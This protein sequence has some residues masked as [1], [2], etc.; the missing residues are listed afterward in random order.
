MKV[1]QLKSYIASLD[2][3]EDLIASFMSRQDFCDWYND[4]E[5]VPDWVWNR[6]E[7]VV[8]F[9]GDQIAYDLK[10]V[11]ENYEDKDENSI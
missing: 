1:K 11:K 8:G 4:G 3:E 7:D 6:I 5:P 9:D 10:W 2:D